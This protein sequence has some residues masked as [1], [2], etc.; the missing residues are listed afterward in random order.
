[1]VPAVVPPSGFVAAGCEA[2]LASP[3][4]GDVEDAGAVPSFEGGEEGSGTGEVGPGSSGMLGTG[5][6]G[7]V[8]NGA[9]VVGGEVVS[10]VGCVVGVVGVVGCVVAV[11][12]CVVGV[13]VSVPVTVSTVAHSCPGSSVVGQ[14]ESAPA[15]PVVSA[16]TT[17][18]EPSVARE[19]AARVAT[20]R[21]RATMCTSSPAPVA[22][23]A[24]RCEMTRC[25]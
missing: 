13:A 9:A 3:A 17:A 14:I 11:V 7:A 8:G 1:V 10:V 19:P 22:V 18:S 5:S 25:D 24:S 21:V 2:G 12:G 23:P 15:G 6:E 20:R 16:P 4:P